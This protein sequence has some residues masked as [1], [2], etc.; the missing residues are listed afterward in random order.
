MDQRM[1]LGHNVEESRDKYP[2]LT[3]EI[4][5]ELREWGED[6]GLPNI[7]DEQLALFAHS[8]YYNKKDSI[9][10]MEVYYRLRA[11]TP[12]FFKD[13]DPKTEI[14]QHS[15]KALQFVAL[16]LPDREGRK[17]IFHRLAN[18]APTAYMFNDGI[19]LLGMTL[20]ASLYFE[21]CTPGYVFLFDMRGVKLAHLARLSV[22]SIRKFFEYLQEGMPIRLQGIHVLNTVWFM[23]KILSLLKPFM[24]RELFEML[25]L[26][27]GEVSEIYEYIPPECLPEDFGGKLDNLETLHEAHCIKLDQLRDYFRDE[28]NLYRGWRNTPRDKLSSSTLSNCQEAEGD[29]STIQKTESGKIDCT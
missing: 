18:T 23:D 1:K 21:G 13:R 24:K 28:E 22:N 2:E 19:K 3:N 26:Y 20:D 15:L 8:C 5:D 9:R 25:H 16:P 10:C 11:T 27:S 14:L 12:E 6:H 4:L 17:I 29:D 7:P